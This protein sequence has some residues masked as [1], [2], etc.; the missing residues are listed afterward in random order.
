MRE[1]ANLYA[2]RSLWND[3][4]IERSMSARRS[5]PSRV[6]LGRM[7]SRG[8]MRLHSSP[9]KSVANCAGGRRNQVDAADESPTAAEKVE[10]PP[11]PAAQNR[12]PAAARAGGGGR[13]KTSGAGDRWCK[14]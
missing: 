1:I 13:A 3:A 11:G 7:T 8:S 2:G 10:Q 4:A 5:T 6:A 12:G 14:R 9:S